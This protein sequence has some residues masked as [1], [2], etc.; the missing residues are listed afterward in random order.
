MDRQ[1]EQKTEQEKTR[2]RRKQ[3]E[4]LEKKKKK[5]KKEREEQATGGISSIYVQ[6]ASTEDSR[7]GDQRTDNQEQTTDRE[8]WIVRVG[9]VYI[10]R[11]E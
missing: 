1:E 11:A 2:S 4:D 5:K 8:S 6:G 3:D 7:I 10:V 9:H